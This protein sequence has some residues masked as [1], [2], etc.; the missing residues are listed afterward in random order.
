MAA[1]AQFLLSY[2]K[3]GADGLLHMSPSNAHETQWDVTDPTTDIAAIL[4][5][6]PATFKAAELL[7]KDPGLV[8][9]LQ[10]ALPKTPPFPRT[11]FAAPLTLLPPAADADGADRIADS[12]LPGAMKHNGENIGLEPIWPYDLIGDDSPLFALAKRTYEH[13]SSKGGGGWSFDSIVA[14]RLEMGSEVG[15]A[16]LRSVENS[17]RCVNGFEGCAQKQRTD[18][19]TTSTTLNSRHFEFYVEETGVVSVA[20]QEA[21]VQDYDGVIRIAP[22]IPPGWNVDGSVY[23]RGKTKVNV[24][25]RNGMPTTVVIESGIAQPIKLRNPWPGQAIDVISG[26]KSATVVDG[27]TGS[28]VTFKAE[29]GENYLVQKHGEP[30]ANQRFET[31]SGTP[32]TNAKS[33]GKVQIGLFNAAQ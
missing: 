14:A 7:G 33:L 26:R 15:A 31:I 16:L 25:V 5:L 32:A 9:Q 28:V 20:L 2:Q 1:T 3:P 19:S 17:A 11:Q 12:Y 29:A 18:L 30:T 22:A 27:A 23:V 4:A 24:Q 13:R 6:Y 21:L 10:A 8:K